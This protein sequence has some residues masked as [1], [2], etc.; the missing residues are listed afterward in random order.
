MRMPRGEP[1]VAP[2]GGSGHLLRPATRAHPAPTPPATG[3]FGTACVCRWCGRCRRPGR[4]D[5][6]RAAGQRRPDVQ[7]AFRRRRRNHLTGRRRLLAAVSDRPV[8]LDGTL[9][10]PQLVP[11]LTSRVARLRIVCRCVRLRDHS[12]PA[13]VQTRRDQR[14]HPHRHDCAGPGRDGRSTQSAAEG[15]PVS[16]DWPHS[17]RHHSTRPGGH[18]PAVRTTHHQNLP[19]PRGHPRGCSRGSVVGQRR[20]HPPNR[21]ATPL[22]QRRPARRDDRA[23]TAARPIGP[24]RRCGFPTQHRPGRSERRRRFAPPHRDRPGPNIGSRTPCWRFGCSSTSGC[25]PN[26]QP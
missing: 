3:R 25:A 2:R 19:P 8:R 21:R 4:R 16:P 9:P 26:R 7:H 18:R 10:T 1:I 24:S 14:R 6:V 5:H 11:R 22:R 20:V 23:A 13:D 15:I 12:S 17:A